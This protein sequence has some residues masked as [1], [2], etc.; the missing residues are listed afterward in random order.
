MNVF[1]VGVRTVAEQEFRLR[2][3]A[4]RWRWLLGAWFG[5]LAVFLLLTR[6]ALESPGDTSPY[7]NNTAR[8]CTARSCCWCWA[9]AC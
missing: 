1:L 8:P 9:S 6:L 2:I 5:S 4:G 7:A 3:R